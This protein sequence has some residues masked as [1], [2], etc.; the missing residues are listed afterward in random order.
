VLWGRFGAL[1][2]GEVGVLG[3]ERLQVDPSFRALSGRLKLM[4]RRHK[5][6]LSSG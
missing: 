5:S 1:A 3:N 6:T 2:G 4:V